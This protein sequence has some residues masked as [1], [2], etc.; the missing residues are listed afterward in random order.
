MIAFHDMFFILYLCIADAFVNSQEWT[1]SRRLR[2]IRLVIATNILPLS[3]TCS[4]RLLAYCRLLMQL[5]EL[6]SITVHV[7]Y[8]LSSFWYAFRIRINDVTKL[9]TNAKFDFKNS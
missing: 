8:E 3:C 4:L 5:Y 6:L 7:P 9:V 1:V 2:D